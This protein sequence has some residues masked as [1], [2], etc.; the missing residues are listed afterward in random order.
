LAW[1]VSFTGGRTL[2][3][4]NIVRSLT[5]AG[6]WTGAEAEFRTAVP[7]GERFAALLQAN[8]GRILGVALLNAPPS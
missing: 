1:V 3:E 2:L 6:R 7:A 4:S 8:D 5:L